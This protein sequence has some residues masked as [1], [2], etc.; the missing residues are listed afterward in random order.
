MIEC[1]NQDLFI[2]SARGLNILKDMSM[3]R[4][5]LLLGIKGIVACCNMQELNPG[6]T[7]V[8]LCISCHCSP[9]LHPSV[10]D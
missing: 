5:F 1:P 9:T 2:G 7:P 4:R 3:D 6:E 8:P 10:C